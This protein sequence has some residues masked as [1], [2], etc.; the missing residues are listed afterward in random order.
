M[1]F[2]N[3][4]QKNKK[5]FLFHLLISGATFV[6]RLGLLPANF[7]PVG[8]Y[9]FYGRNF[10]LFFGG[11]IAFDLI[12][13]GFYPGF[14][15]TYLGFL[16]Y[17]IFGKIATHQKKYQYLLL[18]VASFFFFVLSNFGVWWYWYPTT[19]QGFLACYTAALPF[20]ARTFTGD[21]FF[22]YSFLLIINRQNS[23]QTLKKITSLH[24]L[25]YFPSVFSNKEYIHPQ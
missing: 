24:Y 8:S 1:H 21:L 20:Y 13:G 7:S 10:L 14:I 11:I 16:S 19:W 18:P 5:Q 17:F 2:N 22:G 23:L 12:K 6:S 9:G 4:D 3:Q 25:K 15:F